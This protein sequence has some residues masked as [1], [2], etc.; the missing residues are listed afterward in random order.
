M[1]RIAKSY[2]LPV[3]FG[4]HNF[5]YRHTA[6]FKHADYVVVPSEFSRQHY[7]RNIG[8][9]CHLLPNVV[10]DEAVLVDQQDREPLYL[11]FVNP[12]R[13]KGV[14]VV[15]RIAQE[16]AR[17][18]PDI[19][20][21]IVE[22]RGQMTSLKE[23]GLDFASLPNVNTIPNTPRPSE[24]FRTTRA[25]LVPSLWN[26]SFGL[27]AAEAMTNGIPVLASNRGAL[28]ET[29]GEGGFLFDIPV[30][31]TPETRTIPTA[32]EIRPWIETILRLWDDALFY[33]ASCDRARQNASRWRPDCLG[34]FYKKFFEN[35]DVGDARKV[36]LRVIGR[37][38]TA[39]GDEALQ[40]RPGDRCKTQRST[41]GAGSI[42][43]RQGTFPVGLP[44]P[45]RMEPRV[46]AR[47]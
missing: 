18:R 34:Q 7:W 39:A 26:E 8:V 35:I 30:F 5:G 47:S 4:L 24:F 43:R 21:L 23:I 37:A 41:R 38:G 12:Q 27:V 45:G 15:F 40:M 33:E 44:I 36:L 10:H 19:P 25:L 1:M 31:Y 14:F 16:L 11:T 29:V 17:L 2:D 22:G 46:G 9:A 20:I 32:E 3:V 6:A 13:S 28:P 42:A